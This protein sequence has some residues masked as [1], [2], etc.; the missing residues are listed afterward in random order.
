[1]AYWNIAFKHFGIYYILMLTEKRLASEGKMAPLGARAPYLDLRKLAK[2][3]GG[4][5]PSNVLLDEYLF[6]NNRNSLASVSWPAWAREILAHPRK[7]GKFP[8]GRDIVDSDTRW[9]LPA[10]Y[11]P[12]EAFGR[13]GVGL[14]IDPEEITEER[15]RMI[16]H[17]GKI[18]V[19]SPFIQECGNE[20]KMDEETG[21]PLMA[22]AASRGERRLLWR[23]DDIVIRPILRNDESHDSFFPCLRG[24]YRQNVIINHTPERFFGGIIEL[25]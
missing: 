2:E 15:G 3:R 5:L 20:G 1:M 22:E 13:E 12:K 4:R 25:P 7:G 18:S 19:L 11:V 9:A 6:S 17:P 8:E 21:I 16:V 10:S 23:I 24:N 14:F